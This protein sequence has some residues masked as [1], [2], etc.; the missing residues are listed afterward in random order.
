MTISLLAF[1]IVVVAGYLYLFRTLSDDNPAL[2]TITY[3]YRWGR[4]SEIRGDTNRDGKTDFR[5]LVSPEGSF[6]PH[7]PIAREFWE[8][9]DFDEVFELHAFLDEDGRIAQLEVDEDGDGKYDRTLGSD[10]ARAMY[11][12]FASRYAAQP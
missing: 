8:D 10:E 3:Q 6:S 12:G 2:G 5:A 4:P 7:T 11:Q 1:A 9:R